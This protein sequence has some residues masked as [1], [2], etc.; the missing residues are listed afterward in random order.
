M[1]EVDA[2]RNCR[3]PIR[4][5]G[6]IGWLHEELP[7]YAHEEIT[8]EYAHPVSCGSHKKGNCPIGG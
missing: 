2:C 1:N 5:V 8:C 4:L 3:R 6:D 7:Q